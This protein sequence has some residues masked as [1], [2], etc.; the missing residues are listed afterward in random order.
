MV[1]ARPTERAFDD[2][3]FAYH[4]KALPVVSP[5]GNL[6]RRA[7]AFGNLRKFFAGV[8]ALGLDLFEPTIESLDID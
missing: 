1:L 4:R 2:P 6:D 5:L 8:P 7:E 3:T